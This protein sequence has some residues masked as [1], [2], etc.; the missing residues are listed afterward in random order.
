[1]PSTPTMPPDDRAYAQALLR[2]TDRVLQLFIGERLI[3]KIF[4]RVMQSHA[5][6]RLVIAHFDWRAG[7]GPR[8]TLRWLQER[9][10]CGRTLAAFIGI[11][12]LTG[13]VRAHNDTVDHRRKHLEPTARTVEGLR[14]WLAHHLKLAEDLR[15]LSKGCATRLSTDNDYFE[16]YVRSS[17]IVVDG[18]AALRGQFPLWQWFEDHECGQRI[19][20]ALLRAHCEACLA[21]GAP[22]D[23]SYQFAMSGGAVAAML[24][25]S[26]SHVRNVING[27]ERLGSLSHDIH[28]RSVQLSPAF[29]DESRKSFIHLLTLM[30]LAHERA[31]TLEQATRDDASSSSV[32]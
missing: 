30:A 2:H 14:T 17:I 1:M 11:A 10:G 8:P 6:G 9:T 19:A 4:A 7:V 12:R 32:R 20:Y 23:A 28:R 16:R 5:M 27:A 21:A 22:V 29:L 25:L 13:L 26:K 18:I 31:M 24:G 15:L 3:N